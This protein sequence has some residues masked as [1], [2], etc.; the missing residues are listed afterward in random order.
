MT[1]LKNKYGFMILYP[2]GLKDAKGM[3]YWNASNY[4]CDFGNTKVDDVQYIKNLV[5][6]LERHPKVGRLNRNKIFVVGFS[7]GAFMAHKLACQA[8]D[9]V[10]GIV[11]FSGTSDLRDDQGNLLPRNKLNCQHKK[12]IKAL[13]IHGTDDEVITFNEHD[14]GKAGQV[15]ALAHIQKWANHNICNSKF[16]FNERFNSLPSIKGKETEHYK[17]N[18]CLAPVEFYKI[19]KGRHFNVHNRKFIERVVQF[20]F[21][22]KK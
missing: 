8:S 20:L 4:C 21:P 14:N 13:H 16:E 3:G 17:Y 10:S 12:P 6:E 2:N 1:R 22:P 9:L 18:D 7:N 11:T 5:N 19:I 15:G